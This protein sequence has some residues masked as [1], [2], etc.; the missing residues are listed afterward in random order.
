[1]WQTPFLASTESSSLLFLEDDLEETVCFA[2]IALRHSSSSEW[3]S[4][5]SATFEVEQND[6]DFECLLER[7]SWH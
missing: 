1:M 6:M 2:C 3:Q 5:T 4:R 7:N